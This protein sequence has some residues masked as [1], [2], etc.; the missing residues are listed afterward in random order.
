MSKKPTEVS[1]VLAAEVFFKLGLTIQDLK[2]SSTSEIIL[3][4][5]L[6]YIMY[7]K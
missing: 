7:D 2:L 4:I 3:W 6:T 1:Y 5:N